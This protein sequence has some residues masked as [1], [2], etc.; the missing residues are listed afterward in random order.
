MVTY[1]LW[2]NYF[3]RYRAIAESHLNTDR[4]IPSKSGVRV[5][6]EALALVASQYRE[7]GGQRGAVDHLARIHNVNRTTIWRWLKRA[8]V[9]DAD[10]SEHRVSTV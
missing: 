4:V 5:T 9:D 3:F 2:K 6:P 7:L 10:T 8:G 1:V